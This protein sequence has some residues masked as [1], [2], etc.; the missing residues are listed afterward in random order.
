MKNKMK[1][2]VI[3]TLICTLVNVF[4]FHSVLSSDSKNNPEYA[5]SQAETLSEAKNQEDE[6]LLSLKNTAPYEG[7]EEKY[8][9]FT[10]A[11]TADLQQCD[12]VTSSKR[13]HGYNKSEYVWYSDRGCDIVLIAECRDGVVTDVTKY[14]EGIYWT[15]DGMPS[16]GSSDYITECN[17]IL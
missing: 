2:Y 15:S 12:Y 13:G 16:F 9:N 17:N 7:M 8:I 14:Y 6:F 1:F 5:L 10:A 11:G 4:T 3:V